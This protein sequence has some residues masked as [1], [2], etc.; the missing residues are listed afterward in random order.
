LDPLA[1]R[2]LTLLD[3]HAVVGA[4]LFT[5]THCWEL[6]QASFSAGYEPRIVSH[7][8]TGGGT[9]FRG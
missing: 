3:I 2:V 8:A 9:A 4:G 1:E 6:W 5:P 7:L